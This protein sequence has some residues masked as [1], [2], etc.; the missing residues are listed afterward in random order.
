MQGELLGLKAEVDELKEALAA[1]IVADHPGALEAATVARTS[2]LERDL[3]AAQME[4]RSAIEKQMECRA[5]L[6][7]VQR[8]LRKSQEELVRCK[9]ASMALRQGGAGTEKENG[10][11]T[12]HANLQIEYLRTQ[13]E[14]AHAAMTEVQEHHGAALAEVQE[15]LLI[16][17][18]D[19]AEVRAENARLQDQLRSIAEAQS[20]TV[21]RIR[22]ASQTQGCGTA[23]F[24]RGVETEQRGEH[25]SAAAYYREAIRLEPC[26]TQ[27]HEK[28]A[29]LLC[30][31][32]GQPKEAEPHFQEAA[33]LISAGA[34]PMQNHR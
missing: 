10:A 6:V 11:Q 1:K 3:I 32:L 19:A 29:L 21:S 18:R 28:L 27:A 33:R 9:E 12:D 23:A 31:R 22:C 5:E 17:R 24:N 30:D 7:V 25:M 2:A 34:S 15:E 4:A 8:R 16:A 26:H 14:N 20:A 13:L